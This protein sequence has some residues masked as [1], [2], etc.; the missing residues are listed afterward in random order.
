MASTW[1][2]NSEHKS[3]NQPKLINTDALFSNINII[4]EQKLN[5]KDS[6]D[7]DSSHK[8]FSTLD[9]ISN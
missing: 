2:L 5:G 9:P 8:Q 3:G 4:E 6:Q 1:R 7:I